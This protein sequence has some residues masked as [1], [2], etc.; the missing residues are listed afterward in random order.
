MM[1]ENATAKITAA[2]FS[3]G[4]APGFDSSEIKRVV[5]KNRLV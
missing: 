5:R 4:E 1:E 3:H 2:I